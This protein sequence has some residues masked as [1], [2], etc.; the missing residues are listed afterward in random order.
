[1]HMF[2]KKGVD[3]K[4]IVCSVLW[5]SVIVMYGL[6]LMLYQ[7]NSNT[8]A[9]FSSEYKQSI[10]IIAKDEFPTTE[11]GKESFSSDK[12]PSSK[13]TKD[14]EKDMEMGS[15]KELD[16]D[17]EEGTATDQADKEATE[18]NE[19]ME[20]GEAEQ[21]AD[22]DRIPEVTDKKQNES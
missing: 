7:L 11:Q 20:V 6:F 18:A 8:T 21:V 22:S 5:K 9:Y 19:D 13:Q 12:Q 16:Q 14:Q 15:D 10:S 3:T 1:M 2:K 4:R 17:K